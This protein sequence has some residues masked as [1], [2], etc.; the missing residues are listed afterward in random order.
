[1]S[2][3]RLL[4]ARRLCVPSI[5]Y[6]GS[7]RRT[8]AASARAS[9]EPPQLREIGGQPDVAYEAFKAAGLPLPPI[10]I[11]SESLNLRYSLLATGEFLTML[12][13]FR[14]SLRP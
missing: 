13:W 10:S 7:S 5:V 9:S 3:G 12:S 14:T 8:S 6:F 4:R 2:S 1:M 11:F